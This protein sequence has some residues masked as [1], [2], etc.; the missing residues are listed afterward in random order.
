MYGFAFGQVFEATLFWYGLVVLGFVFSWTHDANAL[1]RTRLF[2]ACE[3]KNGSSS[4]PNT[5]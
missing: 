5:N 2:F 4:N 3:L 1:R